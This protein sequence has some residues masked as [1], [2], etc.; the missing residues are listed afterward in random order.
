MSFLLLLRSGNETYMIDAP[1]R[2]T[3]GL[4]S[5]YEPINSSSHRAS[6]WEPGSSEVPYHGTDSGRGQALSLS[7]AGAGLSQLSHK[8]LS[9]PVPDGPG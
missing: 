9:T 5:W 2:L 4:A 7:R 3:G 1:Q 6:D 8:S